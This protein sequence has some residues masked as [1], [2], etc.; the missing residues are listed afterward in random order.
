MARKTILLAVTIDDSLQFFRGFPE[1][2]ADKGW[3]VHLV[4]NAGPRLASY[5][6]LPGIVTHAI[7]MARTPAPLSD[8]VS[9][10]RWIRLLLSVRPDVVSVGTPKAGMLGSL[11]AYVARVPVRVYLLRGLRMETSRGLSLSVLAGIEKLTMAC[12]TDVH[13][14][15]ATLRER[16]IALDLVPA[17][18]IRAIG[19]GSSN[20]TDTAAFSRENFSLAT[21]ASRGRELGLDPELPVVGFVGR[22][23][24]DKGLFVL[25]D[26]CE[27][28]HSRG[29]RFQL[30][31]VGG[32]DDSS[33]QE[34]IN[35]LQQLPIPVVIAGHV[36]ETASVYPL[37]DVFCLPTF[38]EGFGNAVIE[39]SS[40]A[41]PVVVTDATGVTDTMSDGETGLIVPVGNVSALAQ[42]IEALLTDSERARAMGRSG[43]ELVKARFERSDVQGRY[44][45]EFSS[46]LTLARDRRKRSRD[47]A[48]PR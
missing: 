28:L 23:T 3:E 11:A 9:L 33:G 27:A 14:I 24:R 34:A 4:S 48:G 20:G 42:A 29:I 16:T 30:I 36:L 40:C 32:I 1:F 41:V 26:A 43:R 39:A 44:E 45:Q 47:T 31:V 13:A 37:M 19:W 15:S 38:R 6:G 10:L 25:A 8:L 46:R 7:K 12:A 2:L 35:V 21:L 17:E 5:T 18:K 22:L